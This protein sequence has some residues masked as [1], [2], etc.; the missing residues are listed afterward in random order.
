MVHKDYDNL[1]SIQTKNIGIHS[2]QS[3]IYNP[4]EATPYSILHA[5][6]NEY[7]LRREDHFVD[8]GCGKGRILFLVHYLF[9][10]AVTGIEMD[11]HLYKKAIK[12]KHSY[13]KKNNI[14]TH[15]IYIEQDFAETYRVKISDNIFYFFNPFSGGIFQKVVKNIVDS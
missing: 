4:Y 3:S 9:N 7:T 12:N 10:C 8:F 15:N 14:E 13:V 2:K 1:L 11:V 6:F 5:L